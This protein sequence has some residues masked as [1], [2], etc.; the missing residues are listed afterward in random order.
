MHLIYRTSTL[1]YQSNKKNLLLQFP[2]LLEQTVCL[3]G[4]NGTEFMPYDAE[5]QF[6]L[7]KLDH[8]IEHFGLFSSSAWLA[9]VTQLVCVLDECHCFF[10]LIS[11]R[12]W[13][14]WTWI[15]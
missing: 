14:K 4:E 6:F 11:A 3:L 8:F 7:A 15:I 5:M 12:K 2:F 13:H 10:F 9:S 1:I